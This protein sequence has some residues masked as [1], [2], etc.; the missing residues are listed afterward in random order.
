MSPAVTLAIVQGLLTYGP[1]FAR[2]LRLIFSKA[3]PTEG[4]WVALENLANKSY[5]ELRAEAVARR[6]DREG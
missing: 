3:E 4:D 1:A 6:E 2:Q 5:D